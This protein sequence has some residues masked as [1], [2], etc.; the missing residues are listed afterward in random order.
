MESAG[1]VALKIPSGGGEGGGGEGGGEGGGGKGGESNSACTHGSA[2]PRMPHTS[3][4][5]ENKLA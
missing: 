2:P 4:Y 1:H 3:T 5:V